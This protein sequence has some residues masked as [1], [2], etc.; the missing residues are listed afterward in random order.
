MNEAEKDRYPWDIVRPYF[1]DIALF[2]LLWTFSVVSFC[3]TIYAYDGQIDWF[4]RSGATIVL[5]AAILEY[6]HLHIYSKPI[7]RAV[8]SGALTHGKSLSF[9]SKFRD[10]AIG[11]CGIIYLVLGTLIWGYGDI[12]FK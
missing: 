3:V 2:I 12:P 9:L 8:Q 10:R 4:Q 5:L 6:R 7:H 1:I 11:R